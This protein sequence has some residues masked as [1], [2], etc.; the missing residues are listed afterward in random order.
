MRSLILLEHDWIM[1]HNHGEKLSF[2]ENRFA[3]FTKD[4]QL[5][6]ISFYLTFINEIHCLNIE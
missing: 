1:T 2:T 5:Y 6:L 4:V 3:V